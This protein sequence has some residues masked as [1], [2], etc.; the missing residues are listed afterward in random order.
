VSFS[1]QQR[2]AKIDQ[3]SAFQSE[4]TRL[5]KENEEMKGRVA[6]LRKQVKELRGACKSQRSKIKFTKEILRKVS[7]KLNANTDP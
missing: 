3:T 4:N 2:E 7:K 5:R 1:E 6:N